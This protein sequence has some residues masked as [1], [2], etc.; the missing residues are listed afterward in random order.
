[1][2]TVFRSLLEVLEKIDRPGSFCVSGSVPPILP[3]LEVEQMGSV[4]LPLGAMQ[5]S[6]LASHC[7]R[8]AYGKG[9]KTIVDESVRC[10]LELDS[11]RF[12]LMNPRWAESHR[13]DRRDRSC[14]A[15]SRRTEAGMP[16]LQAAPVRAG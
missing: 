11:D 1:M 5:A 3:G 16:P 15:R 6:E 7:H 9:E 12:S 8:A 2:S 13:A 10:V 4:G 14:R